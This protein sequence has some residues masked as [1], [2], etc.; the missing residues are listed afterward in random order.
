[1]TRLYLTRHGQTEWNLEGRMQGSMESSLTELGRKQAM[2]LGKRLE[3]T[4]IDAVYSSSSQRAMQTA[5]LIVG[6]RQVEIHPV[7]ELIELNMGIWEGRKFDEIKAEHAEQFA[8][9]WNTPHLLKECPGE[10]FESLRCR[11][12]SAIERI[13]QANEG[14][15]V[16]VVAH[17][18]VLKMIMS[19]FEKLPLERL[20]DE[21]IL[22]PTSLSIVE[23]NQAEIQIIKYGDT[24]HYSIV[25]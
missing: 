17:A 5:A 15:D 18:I 3:N 1:M 19:Y 12:I 7:K 8:M 21:R 16:L 23:V 2:Q 25:I 6:S 14:K 24:E 20:F 9:F 13:L 10:S 22:Q 11:A 4:K